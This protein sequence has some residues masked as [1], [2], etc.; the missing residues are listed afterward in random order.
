MSLWSLKWRQVEGESGRQDWGFA[1]IV[2]NSPSSVWGSGGKVGRANWRFAYHVFT[3]APFPTAS[4]RDVP[5]LSKNKS[6]LLFKL[7][8]YR[9][10]K[11]KK[12]RLDRLVPAQIPVSLSPGRHSIPL[13]PNPMAPFLR[14]PRSTKES[15]L[16]S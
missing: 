5:K 6:E 13:H 3:S 11:P 4:L 2:W 7:V 14:G 9:A 8:F 15:A 16:D 12:S 1:S 10:S